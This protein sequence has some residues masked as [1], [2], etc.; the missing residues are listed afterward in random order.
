MA[1]SGPTALQWQ[2]VD[3]QLFSGKQQTNSSSVASSGPT[4]L[5]WQTVDQ[6]LFNGKQWT[7]SSSV[8][9]SKPTALQWQT[10]NQQLFSGKRQTNSSSV[11]NSSSMT[12][13]K[14][15]W[16]CPKELNLKAKRYC[17]CINILI[18]QPSIFAW[19]SL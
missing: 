1:N 3:Q 18:E 19:C 17:S 7:N 2:T 9:N 8:A 13:S 11:A 14:P 15:T 6:Q 10:A 12:N 16:L 5:Q 4:A